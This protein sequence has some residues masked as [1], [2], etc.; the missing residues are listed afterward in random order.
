MASQA[1]KPGV[2]HMFHDWFRRAVFIRVDFVV[3]RCRVNWWGFQLQMRLED[4]TAEVS[5]NRI[6]L[7]DGSKI[8]VLICKPI[9]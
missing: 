6:R 3:M 8:W 2:R 5:V 7:L 1:P 9:R 4:S